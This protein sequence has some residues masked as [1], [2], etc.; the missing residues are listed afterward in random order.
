MWRIAKS[1]VIGTSHQRISMPC[2]DNHY[3]MTVG[4]SIIIA[5]S[6][7]LGSAAHSEVGSKIA[8]QRAAQCVADALYHPTSPTHKV[9]IAALC[10]TAFDDART[11]LIQHAH[12]HGVELRDY[13]CTLLLAVITPHTWAVQHIGDGAVI[14]I[15]ADG[16][17]RTLSTPDNG[18]YINST[19][20]LTNNDYAT[21]MRFSSNTER[22]FGIAVV[23]DG[24]QPM[25]INYKTG[26]AYAGFF[27]P[28]VTWLRGLR[29]LNQADDILASMLDSA[30]FRQKSDD[31]MTLVLAVR[32]D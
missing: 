12:S 18:E 20:P 11:A 4:D 16:T 23:S 27:T 9:D 30:Q 21:Q 8:S 29:M 7:G 17:V 5:V 10:R 24:V 13:A 6:D 25:C 3:V 2:Q 1:S 31:D 32:A 26:A 19:Y 14:G 28:L 15:E 22:L